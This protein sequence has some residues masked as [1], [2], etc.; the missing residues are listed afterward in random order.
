MK[1]KKVLSISLC[2]SMLLALLAVSAY[3]ETVRL[4]LREDW[5][6]TGDLDLKVPEGTTLII[7]GGGKYHIYE[8]G[9]E[10]KNTG[11]GTY[12]LEA[13]T[14]L[15]KLASIP[16]DSGSTDGDVTKP[17]PST[18]GYTY[19]DTDDSSSGTPST[20]TVTTTR[21]PDGSTTTKKTD[22]T[23]GTVTE[24][25]T[26]PDG[27]VTVVETAVNGT[28]TTKETTAN[29]VEVTTVQAR[30]SSVTVSVTLPDGVD[31]ATVTIPVSTA[32]TPGT[33]AVDSGTG[34]VIK[35]SVPTAGGMAVKLDHSTDFILV[36]RSMDFSD[37][38][39][40][41]AKDSIDFVTARELFVGTSDSTFD[42]ELF[43]TRVMLMTVLARLDSTQPSRS[44]GYEQGMA[45]AMANG[46]SDGSNP[47]DPITREQL[48]AMLWRYAGSPSSSYPLNHPDAGSI[49]DYAQTAMAWAVQ[50]GI[51]SGYEDGSLLPDATATR[52]VAAAMIQRFCTTLV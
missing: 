8:L 36:D 1:L 16:D 37:T 32:L 17:G 35:L 43:T 9:G 5:R 30:G 25:T 29:G 15:Y 47:N 2:F 52:A 23:T 46:V 19:D 26:R 34:E 4:T 49:S 13:D 6:L 3:A 44:I 45:W 14:Y 31:S 51:L 28:V 18:G 50:V 42:P 40:H 10:L 20:T 38:I 48:A 39:N 24:T 33:V 27:S 41:W 7:D 22:R 21:N 11:G 12:D